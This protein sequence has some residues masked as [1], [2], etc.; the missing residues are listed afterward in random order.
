MREH[1][2]FADNELVPY[3]GMVLTEEQY[4]QGEMLD[5]LEV[6]VEDSFG[7][8]VTSHFRGKNVSEEQLKI[9]PMIYCM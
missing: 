3:S 6:A 7:L 9:V 8:L 1:Y 2:W 4:H 5:S